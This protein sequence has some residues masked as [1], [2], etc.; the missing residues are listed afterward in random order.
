MTVDCQHCALDE[1]QS[2]KSTVAGAAW[3]RDW[4]S[5]T[6]LTSSFPFH[7]GY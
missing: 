5:K 6:P 2:M 3:L 7:L 4:T 1:T